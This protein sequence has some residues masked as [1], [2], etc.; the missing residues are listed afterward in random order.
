[1][2]INTTLDCDLVAV[3]SSD[4]LALMVELV[5]PTPTVDPDAARTPATLQ[6]VLD[7]SGSMTGDRLEG[8]K[9][10]LLALVD[11]LD[12]HDNLGIVAFDDTVTIV[13]S[14]GPLADKPSVKLAI[15]GIT[16]GGS[17]DLSAGYLRGL[18]EARRVAGPAGATLL[19][20]SD[21]H[22][23]AGV[24]D[25][26]QLGKV[27]IEAQQHRITSSTLGFGLGYDEALLSALAQGGGGTEL[28]AE[29]ADTAVALIAGEVD[30]LLQQVAQATSLRVRWT[31]HV[32]AAKVLNDV[33]TAA[34]PDGFVLELGSFWAGETRRLVLTLD[35]PG[36]AALGL[37]QV[38]T[39]ELTHV[40]LPDLV[41]HTHALPIMVNVVPG[42][43][44]AGRIP[45]AEVRSEALFQRTQQ[46]KRDSSRLLREGRL[47]EAQALLLRASR[48]LDA[49]I[50]AAPP[51]MAGELRA[52]K[53]A[54]TS[55]ADEARHDTSRAAKTMSMQSASRSR[56]RGRQQRG[57]ALR[58][59]NRL[60]GAQLLLEEW[61]LV[62]LTRL[63]PGAD[64]LRAM[65]GAGWSVAACAYVAAQLPTDHP[66][67][68][69]FL[70]AAAGPDDLGGLDVERP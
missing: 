19:L 54:L 60:N 38:A 4:Q 40:T 51:A 8:A 70:E 69:F 6:I 20:I 37:E 58:L 59:T 64:K 63:A 53:D 55:L 21:G 30:G 12:P 25:P 68:D 67:R 31:P 3:E 7:R 44:G 16:D 2:K 42:D 61:E 43:Q 5:A 9:Q 45:N 47:P 18:Q 66:L 50:M 52:E 14:A 28:F 26:L 1:M 10:A 46:V 11:R 48:E 57:A 27:A 13:V 36:I 56:T 33:P 17:T 41:Q 24:T 29:E 62:R 22:A 15:A 49:G 35:I 23:N 34:L 65:V 32:S 39:L